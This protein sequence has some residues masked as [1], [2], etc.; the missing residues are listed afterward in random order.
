VYNLID[1]KAPKSA[2][3]FLADEYCVYLNT[4]PLLSFLGHITF[5][6][7]SCETRLTTWNKGK[8]KKGRKKEKRGGLGYQST[9]HFTKKLG[10]EYKIILVF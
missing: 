9:L 7:P 6:F 5:L 3:Q 2:S 8:K 1:L 4:H 10:S